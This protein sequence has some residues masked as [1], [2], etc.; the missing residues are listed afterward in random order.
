ML[1]PPVDQNLLEVDHR[2]I[3]RM[4]ENRSGQI[5]GHASCLFLPKLRTSG[6]RGKNEKAGFYRSALLLLSSWKKVALALQPEPTLNLWNDWWGPSGAG[7]SSSERLFC[8]ER[9][10]VWGHT[11]LPQLSSNIGVT[12]TPWEGT[13]KT[14]GESKGAPFTRMEAYTPEDSPW[15]PHRHTYVNCCHS[16]RALVWAVPWYVWAN[17]LL[18]QSPRWVWQGCF[19]SN[20]CKPTLPFL[21]I[22]VCFLL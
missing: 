12:P 8:P 14:V 7:A 21:I 2:T 22:S 20:L 4:S 10:G 16:F 3:Q 1:V 17:V 19:M 9:E 11:K 13:G 15:G 18:T 6:S 5:W